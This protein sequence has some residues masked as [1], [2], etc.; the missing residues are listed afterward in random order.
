MSNQAA[1]GKGRERKEWNREQC[2]TSGNVIKYP[3]S[4]T[5]IA[6]L[7]MRAGSIYYHGLTERPDVAMALISGSET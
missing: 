7:S 1:Q 6:C 3:V 4:Q 5:I 2:I